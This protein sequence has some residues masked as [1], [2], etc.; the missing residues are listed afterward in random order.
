MCV[1]VASSSYDWPQGWF[2]CVCVASSSVF[3]SEGLPCGMSVVEDARE[4]CLGC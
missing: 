2:F 1:T 3:F 4:V